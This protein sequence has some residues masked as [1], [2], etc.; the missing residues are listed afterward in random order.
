[1][2]GNSNERPKRKQFAR[3]VGHEAAAAYVTQNVHDGDFVSV[4][5]G[6]SMDRD[7][8]YTVSGVVHIDGNG[9]GFFYSGPFLYGADG[10]AL[11]LL[12]VTMHDPSDKPR[13]AVNGEPL[14]ERTILTDGLIVIDED[15][16]PARYFASEWYYFGVTVAELATLIRDKA[17]IAYVPKAAA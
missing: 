8:H 11:K 14:T 13:P 3:I 12:A 9:D 15:D 1:M 16:E 4:K 5:Y 17:I 7:E 10:S 2:T 6:A